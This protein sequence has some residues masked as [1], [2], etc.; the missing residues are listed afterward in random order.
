MIIRAYRVREELPDF[1]KDE[2]VNCESVWDLTPGM[3]KKI[4][5]EENNYRDKEELQEAL[6]EEKINFEFEYGDIIQ[7]VPDSEML[8]GKQVAE[9]MES[10]NPY[11]CFVYT[12]LGWQEVALERDVFV[13][14][15]IEQL[16]EFFRIA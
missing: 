5:W 15:G 7:I 6:E 3:Y 4:Y 11:I 2:V 9:G 1:M 10:E 13:N 8:N 14:L 16:M 12:R